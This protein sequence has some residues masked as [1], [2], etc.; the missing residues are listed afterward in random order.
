MSEASLDQRPFHGDGQSLLDTLGC[1][2]YSVRCAQRASLYWILLC[3][4]NQPRQNALLSGCI[5]SECLHQRGGLTQTG[6]DGGLDL[7]ST[8]HPATPYVMD[9]IICV[10]WTAASD[11]THALC[12]RWH[13]PSSSSFKG[14]TIHRSVSTTDVHTINNANL[15]IQGCSGGC[16]CI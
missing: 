3:G 4:S 2:S 9:L 16:L 6:R 5:L 8:C 15:R 10:D 14:I 13:H 7:V 12:C 1:A 11:F